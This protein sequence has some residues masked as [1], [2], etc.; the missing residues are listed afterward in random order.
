M[1]FIFI[2]SLFGHG[3]CIAC[4]VGVFEWYDSITWCDVIIVS[5]LVVVSCYRV[6]VC[7][8]TLSMPE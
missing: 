4:I 2:T 6:V 8:V 5:V 7:A 3:V 1:C